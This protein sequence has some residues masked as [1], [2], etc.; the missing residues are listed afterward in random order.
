MRTLTSFTLVTLAGLVVAQSAGTV[1]ATAPAAVERLRRVA[2]LGGPSWDTGSDV[3]VAA[4]GSIY[5]AGRSNS[6]TV[7]GQTG[8]GHADIMLAKYSR[9]GALQWVRLLGGA[10][11]DWGSG[12]AAAP[13][14]SVYVTGRTGG[15]LAGVRNRGMDDI[16]LARYDAAGNRD[17]VRLLGGARDDGGGDVAVDGDGSVYLAGW[18]DPAPGGGT[19]DVLVAKFDPDGNRVW[20]RIRGGTR[21][22]FGWGIAVRDG[23]VYVTG[24]AWSQRFVGHKNAGE[25]DLVL[26]KFTTAGRQEWV[27]TYG[28]TLIDRGAAVAVAGD[29]SVYVT[30]SSDVPMCCGAPSTWGDLLLLKYSA[31]GARKWARTFGT[32]AFDD[33]AGVA[34]APDGRVYVSG[35]SGG[36]PFATGDSQILL[37]KYRPS[38]RRLS[39]QQDG[40][41]GY[42]T[43][44]G[45]ALGAGGRIYVVGSATS[46]FGGGKPAGESDLV[47][48]EYR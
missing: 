23:S 5:L 9:A 19:A 37:L 39:V 25:G 14:G 34:V 40:G 13:D 28:G 6:R 17:W 20:Q 8:S 11:W 10:E 1:R 43:G 2:F 27:R 29:G 38:G 46:A 45:I 44:E 18:T 41:T 26:L 24:Y 42:E 32:A 48:V 31:D 30:G 22:D 7:G 3:A 16:V 36:E 35:S 15:R 21:E 4:D 12:V 47:L 33:G